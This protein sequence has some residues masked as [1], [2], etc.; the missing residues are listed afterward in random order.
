[1]SGELNDSYAIAILIK[2]SVILQ[3]PVV[4]HRLFTNLKIG[5]LCLSKMFC[6]LLFC[7]WYWR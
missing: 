4:V 6:W 1:M 7:R 5:L 3:F 2:Y